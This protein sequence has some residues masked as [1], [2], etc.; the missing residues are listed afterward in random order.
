MG[1]IAE[2]AGFESLTHFERIFKELTGCT[3]LKYRQMQRSKRT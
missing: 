1:D 3:P 2:R